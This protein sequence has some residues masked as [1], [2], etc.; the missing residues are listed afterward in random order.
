MK[1]P[2]KIGFALETYPSGGTEVVIRHVTTYLKSQGHSIFIFGIDF[3]REALLADFGSDITLVTL[4]ARASYNRKKTAALI[5]KELREYGID[6]FVSSG[7]SR[8]HF[9]EVKR[10]ASDT[11]V[12]FSHHSTPFWEI[13]IR[14]GRKMKSNRWQKSPLTWFSRTPLYKKGLQYK[15]IKRYRRIYNAVDGYTVL[16]R[17]YKRETLA[18]LGIA[19]ES[20]TKIYTQLNPAVMPDNISPDKKKQ[21]IYL[22]RLTYSDKR[23]DRLVSI[24]SRI[25]EKHP[26]WTLKI[27]GEGPEKP[28][29]QQLAG[30]SGTQNIEFHS[31]TAD[32]K[33]YYD[34]AS[35]LC[36]TSEFEG[37]GLVLAEAQNQGVIPIAY[38]CSKGVEAVLSPSGE[39]GVLVTPFRE[40]E[41]AD[42]L[43]ELMS[44]G[45]LRS[46]IQAHIRNKNREI[47]PEKVGARWERMFY[48][49]LAR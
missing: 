29:L 3:D 25:W 8:F 37:W 31:Y 19:P 17:D 30:E 13:A 21:V 26:D 20:D 27:V 38:A 12:V 22:G 35:I 45:E 34:E 1:Q 18:A 16:C 42:R 28:K 23:A 5:G 2:L 49:I 11:R 39:N 32:V 9:R 7:V 40:D 46:R 6:L 36:L 4:P 10:M 48:E 14:I 44:D 47:T 15:Y 43:S 24:W 41:Y 33:R